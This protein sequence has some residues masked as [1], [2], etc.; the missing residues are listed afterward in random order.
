MP[1]GRRRPPPSADAL[2]LAALGATVSQLRGT[3]P[4]QAVLAGL[5]AVVCGCWYLTPV[6]EWVTATVVNTIPLEEDVYA[7]GT[8]QPYLIRRASPRRLHSSC[9]SLA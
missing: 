5:A 4:G 6:S 1:Q 7:T 2:A 3:R 9:S 8:F